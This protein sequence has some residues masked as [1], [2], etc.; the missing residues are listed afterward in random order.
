MAPPKTAKITWGASFANTWLFFGAPDSPTPLPIARGAVHE[1]DA[2]NRDFWQQRDDRELVVEAVMI[3]KT[4]TNS[5]TGYS[6]ATT[7]VQEALLWMQKQNP[8]RYFPDKDSGS[9]HTCYLIDFDPERDIRFE[10]GG[11]R[12]RVR[13]R[14]RDTTATA[15]LEY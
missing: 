14:M 6:D 11:N 8:F 1:S 12:R 10:P 7:G 15:F 4:I 3:P 2:G 9:F 5:V 13:L